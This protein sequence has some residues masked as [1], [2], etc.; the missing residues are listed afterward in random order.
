MAARQQFVQRQGNIKGQGED[1]RMAKQ[2]AK[3]LSLYG[4]TPEDAIRKVMKAP[5]LKAKAAKKPKKG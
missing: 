1:K 3:R 4:M 2:P 5:P